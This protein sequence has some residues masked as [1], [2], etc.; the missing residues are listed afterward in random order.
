MCITFTHLDDIF[1]INYR[2]L[3]PI[4]FQLNIDDSIVINKIISNLCISKNLMYKF[5]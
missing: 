2:K 5:V 3:W 1:F 4:D